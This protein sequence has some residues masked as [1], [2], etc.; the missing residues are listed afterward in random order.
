MASVTWNLPHVRAECALSL[1]N[2]MTYRVVLRRKYEGLWF[3]LQS[4]HSFD[5]Q[6]GEVKRIP[7]SVLVAA[8]F[9]HARTVD[10][11][12]TDGS[13]VNSHRGSALPL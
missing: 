5:F 10:P 8:I 11:H 13:S 6:T 7:L 4:A 1:F 9:Q 3:A 12:G 2:A